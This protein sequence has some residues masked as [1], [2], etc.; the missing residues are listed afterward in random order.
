M[1]F[2]PNFTGIIS[3]R[4]SCAYCQY[5]LFIDFWQLLPLND[6]FISKFCPDYS[7]YNLQLQSRLIHSSSPCTYLT[8]FSIDWFLAELQPLIKNWEFGGILK[9]H[10]SHLVWFQSNFTGIISTKSN[11]AIFSIFQFIDFWQSYGP[12]MIFLKFVW[13][14]PFTLLLQLEYNFTVLISSASPCSY[15]TGFLIEW[16][17]AELLLLIKVVVF[18]GILEKISRKSCPDYSSETSGVISSNLY[19]NN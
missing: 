6:F 19:R 13:T 8:W 5:F 2:Q 18:C 9:V 7:Y 12:L 17:L 16:I 4:S 11:C 10:H 15:V 1:Q 3:T 14:T